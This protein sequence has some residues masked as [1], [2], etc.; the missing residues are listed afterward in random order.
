MIP[1]RTEKRRARAIFSLRTAADLRGAVHPITED[2]K[3]DSSQQKSAE[4]VQ[5]RLLQE[6]AGSSHDRPLSNSA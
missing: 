6:L 1:N 3:Y 4:F 2:L 5:G